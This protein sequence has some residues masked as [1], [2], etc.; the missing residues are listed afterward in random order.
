MFA[1]GLILGFDMFAK[2]EL[3]YEI[4]S[5]FRGAR[6]VLEFIAAQSPQAA[7]YSEILSLLSNAITKQRDQLASRGRSKLV[8]RLFSL[9]GTES[10]TDAGSSLPTDRATSLSQP[11]SAIA[12]EDGNANWMMGQSGLQGVGLDGDL[13]AGWDSL[14]LSQWDNFPFDSPRNFLN[15]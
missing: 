10:S 14:E 13:L 11:S 1:A 15:E 8:S 6:E 3:D 2:R 12:F 4:E 7:L 9:S 5:A